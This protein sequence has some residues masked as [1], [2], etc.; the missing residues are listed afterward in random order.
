MRLAIGVMSWVTGS[1]DEASAVR[2]RRLG[3]SIAQRGCTLITSAR[4]GVPSTVVQGAQ[5]AGGTVVGIS[6]AATLIEHLEQFGPPNDFDALIISGSGLPEHEME[7]VQASDILIIAGARSGPP[8]DLALAYATGR[9]IGVL[10]RTNNLARVIEQ[11]AQVCGQPTGAV[12]L[13]DDDPVRL[14]DRL[15][16]CHTRRA[17]QPAGSSGPSVRLDQ[18]SRVTSRTTTR[19]RP[20][21]A[22]GLRPS[23]R[24]TAN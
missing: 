13:C 20:E 22:V 5:T 12:V 23:V 24:L 3:K 4:S 7:L 21:W 11:L 18:E 16:A 6:P 17:E 10:T 15:I 2:I 14:V 19:D 8:H 9:P 1:V